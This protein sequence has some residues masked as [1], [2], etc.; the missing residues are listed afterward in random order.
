MRSFPFVTILALAMGCA[1][2]AEPPVTSASDGPRKSAVSRKDDP[3]ISPMGL[4]TISR[5]PVDGKTV[6]AAGGFGT[7]G[8]VTSTGSDPLPEGR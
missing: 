3:T 8:S 7:H 1:P 4:G 5:G 2:S 6:P